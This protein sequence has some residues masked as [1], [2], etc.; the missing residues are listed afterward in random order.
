[1]TKTPRPDKE[2]EYEEWRIG[3]RERIK[4]LKEQGYR[5]LYMDESVY[6]SKTILMHDYTPLNT[7]HH[8]P[9]TKVNQLYYSLILAV[10]EEDG[11]EHYGIYDKAIDQKKFTDFLE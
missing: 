1:L 3:V 5:I 10:S 11:V 6:T 4:E 9:M 2:E 7:V 8:V